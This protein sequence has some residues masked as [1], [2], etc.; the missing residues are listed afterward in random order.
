VLGVRARRSAI[1]Y[2][3]GDTLQYGRQPKKIKG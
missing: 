1:P 3:T 2:P